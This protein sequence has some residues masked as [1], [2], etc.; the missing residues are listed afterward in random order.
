MFDFCCM[1][2]VKVMMRKDV[3]VGVQFLCNSTFHSSGSG[4]VKIETFF[5]GTF[6]LICLASRLLL[7]SFM[8]RA[9]R[10]VLGLSNL[11]RDTKLGHN[12]VSL[13]DNIMVSFISYH[14]RNLVRR[15]SWKGNKTAV[16]EDPTQ[17]A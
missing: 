7:T 9:R 17:Q 3:I 13:Q 11:L 8:F 2:E 4:E 12:T 6:L 16:C 14:N 15:A 10:G 5:Q 1:T